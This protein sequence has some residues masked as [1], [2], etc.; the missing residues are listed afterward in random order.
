MGTGSC[1]T[2]YNGVIADV[3]KRMGRKAT[4]TAHEGV[5]SLAMD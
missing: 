2:T 3:S 4:R 5:V 1:R